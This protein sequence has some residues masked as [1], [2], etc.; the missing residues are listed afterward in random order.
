MSPV[1]DMISW[2]QWKVWIGASLDALLRYV[3]GLI[4]Y[5]LPISSSS[6]TKSILDIA[7]SNQQVT[8]RKT[9]EKEYRF[10][11]K[12]RVLKRSLRPDEYLK[13]SD[14]APCVPLLVVERLKNEAACMKFI[15]EN[16]DIPV[17]KILDTYEID[18]SYHLWMEFIDGVEMSELTKEQQSLVFPQSKCSVLILFYCR[19]IEPDIN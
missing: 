18:G 9:C 6:V 11:D 7:P 4:R 5:N 8:E 19:R 15:R 13:L 2:R 14:G 3:A 10:N 1:V 16:T 12:G 17:P